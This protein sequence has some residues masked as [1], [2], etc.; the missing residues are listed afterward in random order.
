MFLKKV[1]DKLV[2]MRSVWNKEKKRSDSY[3]VGSFS[4]FSSNR[5]SVV[6]R[7][8]SKFKPRDEAVYPVDKFNEYENGVILTADEEV[9]LNDYFVR[10]K[11]E[12][13]LR[14]KKSAVININSHLAT[15]IWVL[16]DEVGL[17]EMNAEKAAKLYE[18]MSILAK[19]LR[20]VGYK[21][22]TKKET[23]EAEKEKS[24]KEGVEQ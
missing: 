8:K 2:L 13:D 6:F 14:S 11:E 4:C 9:V 16:D 20:S 18:N 12:R 22:P 3:P 1:G 10:D 23:E 15:V 7:K 19:K 24:E 17:A 21:R 5:G